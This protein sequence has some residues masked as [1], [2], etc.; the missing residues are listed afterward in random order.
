MATDPK[1]AVEVLAE[2]RRFIHKRR[3]KAH[4]GPVPSTKARS[5]TEDT[6]G[7]DEPNANRNRAG[8]HAG[9]EAL[10]D[11]LT[12]LALSG[13]GVRSGAFCLGAIQSF[14]RHARMHHFDFLSMVSGGGYAGAMFCDQVM[15]QP[16]VDWTP[17]D[18][19]KAGGNSR[20]GDVLPL[21]LD[22]TRP[23]DDSVKRVAMHGRTMGDVVSL[24]SRH[25]VGLVLNIALILA[26]VIAVASVLAYAFRLPWSAGWMPYLL[27]AGVRTDVS[28]AFFYAVL[29][30]C[31]WFVVQAVHRMWPGDRTA[32]LAR[33]AYV[34]M[35]AVVVLCFLTFLGLGDIE[36]T[37]W[38]RDNQT[39][40]EHEHWINRSVGYLGPALVGLFAT[41][42]LPLIRPGRLLQSQRPDA[43]PL[44]NLFSS[45]ICWTLLLGVPLTAFFALVRENV[46]G[47]TDPACLA[48]TFQRVHLREVPG[49][50]EQLE[51][52]SVNFPLGS[53][54]HV[55]T[56]AMAI[57]QPVRGANGWPRDGG[58][59]DAEWS[60]KFDAFNGKRPDRW[61]KYPYQVVMSWIDGQNY[62]Q[63]RTLRKELQQLSEQLAAR[64]E[65]VVLTDTGLFEAFFERPGSPDISGAAGVRRDR[66]EALVGCVERR[67]RGVY[68][69]MGQTPE[70]YVRDRLRTLQT[71]HRL[72]DTS[73][74]FPPIP[75][76]DN[77]PTSNRRDVSDGRIDEVRAANWDL[78]AGLYPLSIKP[79]TMVSA[80]IVNEHDQ[81]YRLKVAGVAT[82]LFA[83]VGFLTNLNN[84]SLHTIY[85]DQLAKIWLANPRRK[86]RDLQTWTR[87]GPY[88]LWIGTANRMGHSGDPDIEGKSRFLFSPLFCGLRRLGFRPT[89]DYPRPNFALADCVAISGA[90]LTTSVMQSTFGQLIVFVTN[91]RLGQ[92]LR[93]PVHS[94]PLKSAVSPFRAISGLFKL[95]EQRDFLFI[96]DGGHLDN[97]G[98][99]PLLQRRC[100]LIVAIDGSHDPHYEFDGLTRVLHA[101]RGKYGI[102]HVPID[103]TGSPVKA[104]DVLNRLR[105]GGA[106][107]ACEPERDDHPVDGGGSS[108]DSDGSE[109]FSRDHLVAFKILY[110]DAQ[111]DASF[112]DPN[113]GLLIY[114]KL[115]VTGDEPLELVEMARSNDHF[116]HDPTTDQFLAPELFDAYASLGRHVGHDVVKYLA[117]CQLDGL[118]L[119]GWSGDTPAGVDVDVDTRGSISDESARADWRTWASR[120]DDDEIPLTR[121]S[122]ATWLDR[123][124]QY[125][126]R[127]RDPDIL[128]PTEDGET[129][130][131]DRFALMFLA[132]L[133]SGANE[134]DGPLRAETLDRFKSILQRHGEAFDRD[135]EFAEQVHDCK[136]ALEN[137]R[138]ETPPVLSGGGR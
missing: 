87:G 117:E 27:E 62:S 71:I 124:D 28:F 18:G 10:A 31:A 107:E 46:S 52:D 81:R 114:A 36:L 129:L 20:G 112:A 2:E 93:S 135:R 22:R 4:A 56:I 88:P 133:K 5:A 106:A 94:D 17:R 32:R 43:G 48:T 24:L 59:L 78:L 89:S 85:R 96:S 118:D 34:L 45:F 73:D 65:A 105:V 21:H 138:I 64:V 121:R 1:S 12:G 50:K 125:A 51:R 102:H 100:R 6:D 35:A 14:Y 29:A 61:V 92:W 75:E 70:E 119:G 111:P 19:S 136:L 110:P 25:L 80:I 9:S 68:E 134:A 49:W 83:L 97:S 74:L 76:A 113:V 123:F 95:P 84:T 33:G 109:T 57:R 54:G 99:A 137:P 104:K 120:L 26:G 42:L 128:R 53:A 41:T 67:S 38:I 103:N 101:A 131:A 90:A 55:D 98:I 127:Y 116:P 63:R 91:I 69:L 132:W 66:F 79:R 47:A 44:A 23:L 3:R 15:D 86:L 72:P 122:M 37:D 16:E 108:P 13:G 60:K 77:R 39:T 58:P 115:S 82:V 11:Q 30:A 7:N 8:R 40:F 130:A 126:T